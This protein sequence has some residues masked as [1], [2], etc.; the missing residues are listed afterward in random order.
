MDLVEPKNG[1]CEYAAT[2]TKIHLLLGILWLIIIG[3]D[4]RDDAIGAI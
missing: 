1:T 3:R 4:L 2:V